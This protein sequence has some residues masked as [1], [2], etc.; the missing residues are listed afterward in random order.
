MYPD[1]V[2][3]RFGATWAVA[4][5][6]ATDTEGLPTWLKP[7]GVFTAL[8]VVGPGGFRRSL[9]LDVEGDGSAARRRT[10]TYAFAG[11][12]LELLLEVLREAETNDGRGV[13]TKSKL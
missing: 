8:A 12:A 11:G 5:S 9:I 3:E 2:R 4:E 7:A 6:G 1:H 13:A 10:S